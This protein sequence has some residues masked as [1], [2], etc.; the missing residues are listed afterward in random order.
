MTGPQDFRQHNRGHRSD[1]VA[2]QYAYE[3][4]DYDDVGHYSDNGRYGGGYGDGGSYGENGSYGDFDDYDDVVGEVPADGSVR[5]TTRVSSWAAAMANPRYVSPQARNKRA[6][7][8]IGA[9]LLVPGSAQIA[10][11]NRKIG[12][13]ALTV[14]V[15]CWALLVLILLSAMFWRTPLIFLVTN[16]LTAPVISLVLVALAIGWGLLFLD[17]LRL[18]KPGLLA[19]KARTVT[20]VG[21]IVAMVITSGGLGYTAHLINVTRAAVGDIFGGG[22]PFRPVDGRYNI[23]LMGADAGADRVGLRPDSMTVISIDAKSGQTVTISLPRNLQNT[24]FPDDS[25]MHELYP[26][27]YNCGD[28][29]LLNAIYT[30]VTESHPDIYGDVQDPGAEA[31]MDAASGVLG[32]EVQGYAMIDMAGFE[33]LIDALGGITIDVGGEV[34]IGG[35]TNEI[36][37]LPNPIDGY[38]EPGVQHLDGFHA[39]WYAR[40]REGA[41]D[42]DRQ[43]RQRCVQTAMLKQLSPINVVSKFEELAAAGTQVVET[44]IPQSSIGSF[45]DL[46]LEAQNHELVGYAAGP[47]YYDAMF[48]TYPD[49]N[50]LHADVQEL[51]AGADGTSALGAVNQS[52]PM[53]LGAG[54][55][56][57][58]LTLLPAETGNS[59]PGT[60]DG[61]ATELSPN[62]TCSVP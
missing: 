2:D 25:P 16:G 46:A 58:G 10:A 31:M 53:A 48:P 51:L 15:I 49:Y 33:Q 44:D 43:A 24:P 61:S 20:I 21:T 13:V 34:P 56:S 6:G 45:V 42:Y 27:G 50:Q 60:E 26:E 62:G 59:T 22:L 3:S 47:P 1:G 54:L 55:G 17:A 12:R 28:E 8:L 5:A 9:T 30:D 32:I 19:N 7:L 36:T 40:S 35:G 18:V 41:S 57:R 14:T 52:S 38:I 23:L 39:L 29:C 37:G 4:G 11:G